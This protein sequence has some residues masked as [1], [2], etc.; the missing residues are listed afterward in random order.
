M[1]EAAEHVSQMPTGANK[2]DKVWEVSQRVG[3]PQ[4]PADWNRAVENSADACLY[5][6]A[7][8]APMFV[9]PTADRLIF[10]ECR[11]DGELVGGAILAVTRHRWHR[12]FERRSIRTSLGPLAVPPFVIDSLNAK[13][14][15]AAW[16]RLVDACVAVAEDLRSD[17]I[18][19]FDAP[20]SR[21]VMVERPIQNRYYT[22]THWS[23]LVMY[24][25]VLDLRQDSDT[26]WRNVSSGQRGCIKKARGVLQLAPGTEIPHGRE[27]YADLMETMFDRENLRLL[28]RQQLYGIL[29]N[30]YDGKN[31]HAFF[32]LAD[33]KPV[34]VTGVARNGKIA[35]YLHGARSDGA[36]NGAA[37]LSLW[38]GIE[39]AR[40]VGCEWFELGGIIPER[41]RERLR[42]I[43]EFKKSFGGEIMQVHGGKREFQSLRRATFDC[44][45]LWGAELKGL[46]R[47][48]NPFGK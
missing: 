45:D 43:R 48:A 37:S 21:R 35:S 5:H 25:Y 7:E 26:L 30:V 42:A 39:W 40:S 8:I 44:I 47:K 46:F 34:C 31:G 3:N 38:T 4:S 32:C 28:T 6:R 15:E 12:F 18:V 1:N 13:T 41:N 36:M 10:V 24:D 11:L 33:G 19:L 22:S 16:D 14:A 17:F 23:N 27:A 29:E 9:E 20:I 2:A